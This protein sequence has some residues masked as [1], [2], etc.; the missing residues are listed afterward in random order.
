MIARRRIAGFAI[1]AAVCGVVSS[2]AAECNRNRMKWIT[3]DGREILVVATPGE[4]SGE[5]WP[6]VFT[7]D[8]SGAD[9]YD[10][11]EGTKPRQG[12]GV[13]F[14]D[15]LFALDCHFGRWELASL[16]SPEPVGWV[17]AD[18]VIE[19]TWQP[20][21][22]GEAKERQIVSGTTNRT[23]DTVKESEKLSVRVITQPGSKV[24]F[25]RR[26]GE[27]D[28]AKAER[29]GSWRWYYLF[30]IEFDEEENPWFLV[31]DIP[32]MTHKDDVVA[33]NI[34]AGRS[35]QGLRG[36]VPGNKMTVWTTNLVLELNTS[37]RAVSW[38]FG[39]NDP[40]T[41]FAEPHLESEPLFEEPLDQYWGEGGQMYP[42]PRSHRGAREGD[43]PAGARA[44]GGSISGL[45]CR[46]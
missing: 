46:T 9:V 3:N 39:A 17:D 16:D 14:G 10:A 27:G 28:R 20:L 5:G 45:L 29:V 22:V 41:V 7:V 11:G 19:R 13:R 44:D 36:W 24:H 43:S 38:R 33:T 15:R 8:K 1:A 32:V 40:A 26:P 35:N 6:Q 21:T 31:G 42:L 25:A 18:D 2:A 4:G 34:R 12:Q 37:N 23:V 30:D